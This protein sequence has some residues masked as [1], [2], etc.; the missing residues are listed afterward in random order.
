[1]NRESESQL[2]DFCAQQH[3]VFDAAQWLS[4]P[5]VEKDE[6]AAAALFLAGCDWYTDQWRPLVQVAEQLHPGA[7]SQT[8]QLYRSTAFD[9]GRFANM[10][11][12]EL[13]DHA[14]S[15]S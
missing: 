4:F 15:A 9:H 2:I 1:M 8:D 7:V 13:E 5:L 11:R 12:R 10:L 6:L 14:Q 3:S